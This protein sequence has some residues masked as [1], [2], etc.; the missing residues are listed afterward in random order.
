MRFRIL[1]LEVRILSEAQL[2]AIEIM[3]TRLPI[4][5]LILLIINILGGLLVLD[6]TID[7]FVIRRDLIFGDFD[8]VTIL[9]GSFICWLM[10]IFSSLIR[11]KNPSRSM[12]LELVTPII[13]YLFIF[14]SSIIHPSSNMGYVQFDF[15]DQWGILASMIGII[16][17]AAAQVF[18]FTI[19]IGIF[20]IVWTLNLLDSVITFLRLKR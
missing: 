12:L 11:K 4:Q 16:P 19:P 1:R 18:F 2:L 17:I 14:S 6:L 15:G 10:L 5:R 9:P 13:M 7:A 20:W 8:Y 3:L